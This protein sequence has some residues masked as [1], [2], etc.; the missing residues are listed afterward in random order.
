[1]ATFNPLIEAENDNFE[2]PEVGAWSIQ[3]WKLMGTYCS[4]FTSGMRNIWDQLVYIDLFAGAGFARIKGTDRIYYA[5]P[6]IAMSI[7]VKFDKYILCEKDP[8]LFKALKKR[9][10]EI[11]PKLNVDLIKGDSNKKIKSIK[12]K[13]PSYRKGN[14]LLPFCF[15][16]PFSVKLHF[17]II[18]EL[19]DGL[20][21]FLILLALHMDAN[22]NFQKYLDDN[23]KRI[24]LFVGDSNWRQEFQKYDSDGKAFINYLAE[25]YDRN[26]LNLGY[27]KPEHKHQVRS[28]IKNLP[29]YYLAFY[30]K[31]ERGNDFYRKVKRTATGQT[32]FNF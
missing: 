14:T 21:D 19:A 27:K 12:E 16:D 31:H 5:S 26:M 28:N 10:D 6:L 8:K 9:V 20:M 25:K 4:I 29:L 22:R 13:I 11:S 2:I 30:S 24:E 1:M 23:S 18:E 7:P 3:K 15:V 17:R 32:Q